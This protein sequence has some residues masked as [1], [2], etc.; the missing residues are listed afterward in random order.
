VVLITFYLSMVFFSRN[1]SAPDINH[2]LASDILFRLLEFLLS[3]LSTTLNTPKDMFGI[4]N[5]DEI[6][7]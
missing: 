2:Q 3:T 5:A 6:K 1:K 7:N 4:L